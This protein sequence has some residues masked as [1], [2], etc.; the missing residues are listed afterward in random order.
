M[1]AARRQREQLPTQQTSSFCPPVTAGCTRGSEPGFAHR[2]REH[3]HSPRPCESP[4]RPEAQHP[5]HRA[6]VQRPFGDSGEKVRGECVPNRGLFVQR[7]AAGDATRAARGETTLEY[8]AGGIDA[9]NRSRRRHQ[10][11][12]TGHD[13]PRP[14]GQCRR[15]QTSLRRTGGGGGLWHCGDVRRGGPA[16]ELRR[17]HHR[18]GIGGDDGLPARKNGIAAEDSD[19][20]SQLGRRQEH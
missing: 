13:R 14:P 2:H 18:A 3:T 10:L 8:F 17:R 9:A 15:R 19:S 11:S 6:L 12:K 4:A 5:S 16:R 1:A 20:R 7:R